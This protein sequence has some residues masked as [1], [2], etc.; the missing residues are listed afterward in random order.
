MGSPGVDHTDAFISRR[1][2]IV[3]RYESALREA[4]SSLARDP[5]TLQQALDHAEFVIS[6]VI[7]S[8]KRGEVVVDA[9]SMGLA[10]DIGQSRA[11]HRVHP[12]ESLL[13]AILMFDVVFGDLSDLLGDDVEA[14]STLSLTARALHRSLTERVRIA[15]ESY[16]SY[17]LNRVHE[18][19]IDERRR[20][21]RELHDR[22]GAGISAANRHLE[23]FEMWR[24]REPARASA[25]VSTAQEALRE[26]MDEVRELTSDL[27]VRMPAEGLEKA[28]QSYLES[29]AGKATVTRVV[30]NGD[31][32]W[33][34]DIVRGELF[35]IVREALRNA[36]THGNPGALAARIDITPD[37]ARA[38]VEDDGSGFDIGADRSGDGAGIDSMNERAELLGGVASVTSWPG[39]GTRVEVWIPLVEADPDDSR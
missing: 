15:S 1:E 19:L 8:L 24:H 16:T 3:A 29:A 14:R 25:R 12:G 10:R 33:V 21:A 31:E 7:Q 18:A 35:L 37:E 5:E 20:I 34:S 13:A 23:L 39:R 38:V 27:R 22:V 11:A 32:S 2:E 4:G 6:D 17:L 30:V 28:L 26:T 36:I 9:A